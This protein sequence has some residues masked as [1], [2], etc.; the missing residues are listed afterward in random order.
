M[1]CSV[2]FVNNPYRSY[3]AGNTL[4]GCLNIALDREKYIKVSSLRIT[5]PCKRK[6]QSSFP[7]GRYTVKAEQ[8][9]IDEKLLVVSNTR[10][11]AGEHTFQFESNLPADCPPSFKGKH[12]Q[13]K[14]KAVILVPKMLCDKKIPFEFT[15]LSYSPLPFFEANIPI[16]I[17]IGP[18]KTV[19]FPK[20]VF[21][22]GEHILIDIN[23]DETKEKKDRSIKF[24]LVQYIWYQTKENC[25]SCR[26]QR[27]Q[28]GNVI[29]FPVI[30]SD[31]NYK[32]SIRIPDNLPTTLEY[33]EVIKIRYLL[34]I[35]INKKKF[36]FPIVLGDYYQ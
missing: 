13:I 12:G 18:T 11:P 34:K 2:E 28:K 7:R 32:Q 23:I 17:H 20:N 8:T 9:F 22:V 21:R 24:F 29:E 33:I 6:G 27:K 30:T 5:N 35:L 1:R 4:Y 19:T 26:S 14:Y 36:K 15:I 25:H 3:Y 31:Y 10:L 16:S